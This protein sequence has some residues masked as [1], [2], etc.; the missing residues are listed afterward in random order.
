MGAGPK[1]PGGGA[2][3]EKSVWLLLIRPWLLGSPAQ[4]KKGQKPGRET[5]RPLWATLRSGSSL[6]ASLGLLALGACTRT[7]AGSGPAP[8]DFL[9]S[10]W[11]LCLGHITLASSSAFWGPGLRQM[12]R[13]WELAGATL[14]RLAK[15]TVTALSLPQS[16]SENRWREKVSGWT[17]PVETHCAVLDS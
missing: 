3:K 10:F 8:I 16:E 1:R 14:A 7:P 9:C 13:L 12:P 11:S 5:Q 15:A 4:G 2:W 6:K 17:C